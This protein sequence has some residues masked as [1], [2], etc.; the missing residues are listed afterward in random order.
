MKFARDFFLAFVAAVATWSAGIIVGTIIGLT[1]GWQEPHGL[2]V[3][4]YSI[5]V[6]IMALLVFFQ[7]YSRMRSTPY[8]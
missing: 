4:V 1:I 5:I 6:V 8:D 3:H 7:V 2:A